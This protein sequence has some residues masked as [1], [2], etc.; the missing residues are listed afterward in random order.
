[1]KAPFVDVSTQCICALRAAFSNI[2][3][4]YTHRQTLV[5]VT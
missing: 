1:M 2:F 3:V 4:S 5:L